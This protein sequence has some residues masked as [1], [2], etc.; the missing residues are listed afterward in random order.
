M[1]FRYLSAV[2][3][4]T[5]GAIFAASAHAD[6]VAVTDPVRDTLITVTAN[7]TK[8]RLD[9]SGQ[10]ISVIGAAE[11]QSIQGPDL[12][13][14]LARLPGVSVVRS[15]GLGAVT[16]LFVR[17]ANSE[18]LAVLVDGVAIE[19]V[20]APSGGYDFGGLTMGGIGKVELLRGSNSVVWG[21]NAMGGVLAITSREID[22][23]EASV[24][25]NSHAS[26]DAGLSAGVKR[27]SYAISVDGGYTRTTGIPTRTTDSL[28]NGFE[29]ARIATRGRLALAPGLNLVAA[30]RYADNQLGID[31]YVW[32]VGYVNH[33]EKQKGQ[34]ASG[35]VGLDYAGAGY[36]VTTGISLSSLRRGY[37]DPTQGSA[38]YA[39][40]LGTTT[41]VDASGHVDLPAGFALLL[42]A[43]SAW[44]HA[45]SFYYS[46]AADQNARQTSGHGLLTYHVSR[47]DV[48]G[49]LR[50]DDHSAFG[51]HWTLGGN[52]SVRVV[53]D[54]RLRASY[55][56]GFKAPTLYQLYDPYSG[57]PTLK[58][59]TSTS[60]DLALEKGDRNGVVHVALTGFQRD[61]V[62]L[63][64]YVYP[65]YRNVSRARARG[66]EAEIDLRPVDALQ[67]HAAYT[68]VKSQNLVTGKDLARRPRHIVNVA[69]DWK[70]PL[71]GL[72]VGGDLRVVANSYDNAANT[73]R[74]GSY[75]LAGLHASLPLCD[76]AEIF[77]RIENLTDARYTVASGY[78][79]YGRT[80]AFGLR[81]RL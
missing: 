32:P 6:T 5:M 1:T 64:D 14:A 50:V 37:V 26:W 81:A 36:G 48:S 42:G 28:P 16:S 38:E 62:N 53:D 80:A 78:N 77:A 67:V 54:I 76:K 43:D 21:A 65:G 29:Q 4:L 12:T 10:T 2:S 55:G 7:G 34:Q 68:Y 35:R 47:V 24:E 72:S 22:G 19:D 18:Q 51:T 46:P 71:R 66:V 39:N 69:V 60:Y 45:R 44:T 30:L 70:T 23:A 25:S 31:S 58:P 13:R 20:A 59:E 49:G 52:G 8:A 3:V 74:L 40:Y 56:E 17:G 61:T 9:Q 15:G 75:A 79:T 41:K 63:I 73:V 33:G 11:L 57:N 27:E